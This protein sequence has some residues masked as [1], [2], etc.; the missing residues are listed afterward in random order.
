ME[1]SSVI[2]IPVPKSPRPLCL[3]HKTG[4]VAIGGSKEAAGLPWSFKVAHRMFRRHHGRHGRHQVLNMFKIVTQR[5]PR[6]LVTQRWLKWGTYR[7][8]T[9]AH[10]HSCKRDAQWLANG[11]PVIN[12]FCCKTQFLSL[13]DASNPLLPPLC[14][15]WA[16]NNLHWT[17][18]VVTIIPAFGDHGELWATMVMPLP[19]LCFLCDVLCFPSLCING[20]YFDESRKS[21]GAVTQK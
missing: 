2:D 10:C 15:L 3:S 1:F 7:R 5:S 8:A 21:T 16:T 14:L 12:A 19:S 13:G 9:H 20:G 6:R 11:R 4:Q 18:I 17:I